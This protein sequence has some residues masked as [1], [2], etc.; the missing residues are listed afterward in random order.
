MVFI[1]N[2]C[3]T[4]FQGGL[5][6]MD[7]PFYCGSTM[8]MTLLLTVPGALQKRFDVTERRE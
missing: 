4:I 7:I 6:T 8:M 1:R 5:L 2:R 3:E